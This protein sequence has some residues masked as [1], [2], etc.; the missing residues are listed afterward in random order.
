MVYNR[1]NSHLRNP[2]ICNRKPSFLSISAY[3]IILFALSIFV[4]ILSSKDIFEDEQKK[5][6]PLL[7]KFKPEQVR[8]FQFFF[9]P[10]GKSAVFSNSKKMGCC[11]LLCSSWIG[12]FQNWVLLFMHRLRSGFEIVTF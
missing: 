11:N 5:P 7:D 1:R 6:I 4:F 9:P 12:K 10:S 3:V 2:L 8:S